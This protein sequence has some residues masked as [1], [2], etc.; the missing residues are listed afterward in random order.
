MQTDQLLGL[1]D[2]IFKNH[3]LEISAQVESTYS[4]DDVI[5]FTGGLFVRAPLRFL[6]LANFTAELGLGLSSEP[7]TSTTF[8]PASLLVMHYPDSSGLFY[9]TGFSGE[10][11]STNADGWVSYRAMLGYQNEN[12]IR[13]GM[14]VALPAT[15][16]T[17]QNVTSI[18]FNLVIPFG[19]KPR[20]FDET[21][22]KAIPELSADLNPH[23]DLDAKITSMNEALYLIK[24]D[25]G[26]SD[27]IEKGQTFD[28]Y[29]GLNRMARA[30][31]IAVKKDEAALNVI[32]YNQEYWI[33]LG[34]SARRISRGME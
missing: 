2:K 16:E 14:E 9:G 31:V 23:Y 19:A 10:S 33:E 8:V 18:C 17:S 1:S 30:Q 11:A 5:G 22:A 20:T 28:I 34:F 7:A 32:E 3:D 29:S 27:S 15:P 24:I 6:G 21:P 12:G 4:Q 25:K 13:Y 26:S